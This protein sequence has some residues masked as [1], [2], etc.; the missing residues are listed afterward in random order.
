MDTVTIISREIFVMEADNARHILH[1]YPRIEFQI[2]ITLIRQD[3][4]E[5]AVEPAS[6]CSTPAGVTN[7]VAK[8]LNL[9]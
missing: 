2:Q 9:K 5:R 6:Y 8:F 1:L 7:K 3:G 4:K